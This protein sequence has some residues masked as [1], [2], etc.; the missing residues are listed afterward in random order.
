MA[1]VRIRS[2][3]AISAAAVAAVVLAAVRLATVAVP[4]VSAHL[5]RAVVVVLGRTGQVRGGGY[6]LHLMGLV[7]IGGVGAGCSQIFK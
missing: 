7:V 1:V 2:V 3:G 4:P 5:L 6:G